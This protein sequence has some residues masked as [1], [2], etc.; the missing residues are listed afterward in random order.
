MPA[1]T[2]EAD[3]AFGRDGVRQGP[4]SD[5]AVIWKRPPTERALRQ[6]TVQPYL[7]A[8]IVRWIK[9]GCPG[10]VEARFTDMRG[11]EWSVIEKVPVLTEA[12]LRSD[13]SF[14]QAVLIAC[15]IVTRGFDDFGREFVEVATERP[16]GIEATD[17]TANFRVYAD[18]IELGSSS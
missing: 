17:G 1:L 6:T 5:M 3:F 10:F 12:N 8:E 14:P 13:S 11:R 9:D 18:Q 16:W 4:Q 7:R 2:P 15:E